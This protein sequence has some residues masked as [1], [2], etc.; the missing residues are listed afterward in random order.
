MQSKNYGAM[1]I[2]VKNDVYITTINSLGTE[3]FF[4]VQ[5]CVY[6]EAFPAQ[7]YKSVA[8]FINV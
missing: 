5:N 2:A 6:I 7:C 1:Y 4:P 8:T 3:Y